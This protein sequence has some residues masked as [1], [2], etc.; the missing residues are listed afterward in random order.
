MARGMKRSV[1]GH[2]IRGYVQRAEALKNEAK[3][4]LEATEPLRKLEHF[5]KVVNFPV[6]VDP[7]NIAWDENGFY[8]TF[9]NNESKG[10]IGEKFKLGDDDWSPDGAEDG[11]YEAV[12]VDTVAGIIT[13]FVKNDVPADATVEGTELVTA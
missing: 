4:L 5:H 8:L 13:F 1:F 10:L 11:D 12:A 2:K 9:P 6:P 7:E 3:A